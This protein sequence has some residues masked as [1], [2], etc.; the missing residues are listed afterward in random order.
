MWWNNYQSP[1][2][3]INGAMPDNLSQMRMQQQPS[4]Q[5]PAQTMPQQSCGLIFVLGEENAKAYPVA[6]N[7]TVTLWDKETQTIYIKSVDAAGIPSMRIIEW[8]DREAKREAA[9]MDMSQYVT[10]EEF[11]REIAKI[12][13]KENTNDAEPSL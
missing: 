8:R 10:R 13:N 5:M 2:Y 11:Q 7:N 1:Y 3:P 12:T 9:P 4:P 6:P